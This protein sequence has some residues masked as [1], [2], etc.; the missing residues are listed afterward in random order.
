MN[1][2]ESGGASAR[3]LPLVHEF[4]RTSIN[5]QLDAGSIDFQD[6][7]IYRWTLLS[8]AHGRGTSKT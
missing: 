6:T 5:Y 7:C 4:G 1:V 8:V 3:L 2:D